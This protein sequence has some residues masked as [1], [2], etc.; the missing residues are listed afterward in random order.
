MS[1]Q[2]SGSASVRVPATSANLGPGFDSLALALD[3]YDDV[4]VELTEGALQFDISG[5]GAGEVARDESHLVVRALRQALQELGGRTGGMTLRS[6]NRIPHGRGLGSSAAAICA[7]VLLARELVDG[8]R[9]SNGQVGR[10]VDDG[11]LLALASSIEGH[12]DNVAACLF[13]GATLA[14][15]DLATHRAQ[16]LPLTLDRRIGAVVFVPPFSASTHEARKLLPASVPHADAAANAA[17]SALLVAALTDRPDLLLT[18]TEDRLHQPY[19]AS[20]MPQSADL[21]RALRAA[22]CA[23]VI[24]GAGPTVL[25][26]TASAA[27]TALAL[28]F[29]PPRWRCMPLAV[30]SAGGVR[31]ASTPAD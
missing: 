8:D 24:S 3:L 12:P 9:A 5:A 25:A 10:S 22:G 7:G 23:A 13:G 20:A 14:W 27:D 16:A 4:S 21:V 28:S 1:G 26:L 15:T 19:R 31:S 18:A 11:G 17:R 29:A 6:T 2:L 30:A